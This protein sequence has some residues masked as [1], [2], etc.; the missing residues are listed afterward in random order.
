MALATAANGC[1]RARGLQLTRPALVSNRSHF[2]P[3]ALGPLNHPF[4]H[5]LLEAPADRFPAP[6]G[7]DEEV[8]IDTGEIGG[9]ALELKGALVHLFAFRRSN[10]DRSGTIRRAHAH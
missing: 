8:R 5:A 4:L 2:P 10:P 9:G 7:L 1:P 6:L 3:L